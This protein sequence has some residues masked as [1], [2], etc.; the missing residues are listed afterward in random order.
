VTFLS[1]RK[2]SEILD[3]DELQSLLKVLERKRQ[4]ALPFQIFGKKYCYAVLPSG[5]VAGFTT[6]ES[7]SS[8]VKRRNSFVRVRSTARVR[9]AGGGERQEERPAYGLIEHFLLVR[10]GGNLGAY[11]YPLCVKSS[12]DAQSRS[13]LPSKF[14]DMDAFRVYSGCL[15]YVDVLAI[16]NTVET[17]KREAIHVVLHTRDHFTI[18]DV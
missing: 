17:L 2:R 8:L 7:D 13:G 5:A 14:H 6:L 10:V 16:D 11:A 12:S 1:P 4:G 18:V 9:T 15:W 3:D